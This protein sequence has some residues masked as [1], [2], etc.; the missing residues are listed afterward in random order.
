MYNDALKKAIKV[1]DLFINLAEDEECT[2]Q[3]G[4]RR[5]TPLIVDLLINQCGLKA[6][7]FPALGVKAV[8][9]F[10]SDITCRTQLTQKESQRGLSSQNVHRGCKTH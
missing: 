10:Y 5:R 6:K 1:G 3:E 4:A 9:R 2:V 7:G 8:R